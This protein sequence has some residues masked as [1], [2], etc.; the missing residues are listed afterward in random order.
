MNKIYFSLLALLILLVTLVGCKTQQQAKLIEKTP[1]NKVVIEENVQKT[2][3][4]TTEQKQTT[5]KKISPEVLEI[6]NQSKIKIKSLYY[7]YNGPETGISF[8][9]FYLKRDKI[10][11]IPYRGIM[12]LELPESYDTIFINKLDNTSQ[13]YCEA[14]YCRYP[15]KKADLDYEKYYIQTPLDWIQVKEAKKIGEETIDSRVTWKL[16]T[17]NGIMWVDVYYGIP[18]K[19]ESGG[20]IYRF[21]QIAVNSL[22]D[23]DVMPSR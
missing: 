8:Y 7:K 12:A 19:V 4:Q 16:E 2:P 1:E 6:L 5:E 11:Y 9:D 21:Q 18:L 23:G 20:K 15:G 17:E 13:S 22:N 14:P 10:K 3:A